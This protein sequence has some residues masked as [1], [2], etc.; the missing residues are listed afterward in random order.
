MPLSAYVQSIIFLVIAA[1]AL[2]A[3][4]GTLAIPDFWI[5]LG[6]LALTTA[7]SLIVLFARPHPRAH[8]AGGTGSTARAPPGRPRSARALRHRRPRSRPPARERQRAGL[9][10]VGWPRRR[11]RGIRPLSLVDG[12]Q[13]I[14]LIGRPHPDRP[15]TAG[16]RCGAVPVRPASGL[17]GSGAAHRFQADIALG[18][19]IATG[20]LIVIGMPL[21]LSRLIGEDR[22][23]AAELP[24]YR[25]YAST[26]AGAYSG[27]LVR[28]RSSALGVASSR[29]SQ[30]L[31]R[32]RHI[33][34]PANKAQ[35]SDLF[36]NGECDPIESRLHVRRQLLA[37]RLVIEIGVQVG[38]DGAARLQP[39]DPASASASEKWLGCGR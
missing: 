7:A 17:F 22:L 8:A 1:I 4:A 13:P 33:M 15:R 25:D 10:S 23:L 12:S 34:E 38:Q 5:Y 11:R 14:L 37:Q 2:F 21:L 36:R 27:N 20:L 39:L 24:G 26:S 9:A 19:W 35:L 32:I 28:K 3:S 29:G 16:D 30:C 31:V 6:I 18:S